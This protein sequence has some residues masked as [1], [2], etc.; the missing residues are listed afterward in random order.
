MMTNSTFKMPRTFGKQIRKYAGK[1]LRRTGKRG[2]YSGINRHRL[3]NEYEKVRG[4]KRTIL[5]SFYKF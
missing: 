1:F 2:L 4:M 3:A 5:H